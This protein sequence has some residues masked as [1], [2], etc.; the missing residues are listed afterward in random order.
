MT[1]ALWVLLGLGLNMG[2]GTLPVGHRWAE[3]A[4]LRPPIER[5]GRA[6]L[7]AILDPLTW[8]PAVGAGVFAIDHFDRKVSDWPSD[9]TPLFASQKRAPV[10]SAILLPTQGCTA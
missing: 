3:D 8:A 1:R 2:C 4:T 6:A 7:R 5:V 9:R 10:G